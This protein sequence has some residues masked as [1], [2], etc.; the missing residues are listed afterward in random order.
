M[1]RGGRRR[2]RP[3]GAADWM[4]PPRVWVRAVPTGP[5]PCRAPLLGPAGRGRLAAQLA[6]RAE[7]PSAYASV[8]AL[9]P[10]SLL[11]TV[12]G[13]GCPLRLCLPLLELQ[14]AACEA[15]EAGLASARAAGAAGALGL[16]AAS[17]LPPPAL[18]LRPSLGRGRRLGNRLRQPRLPLKLVPGRGRKVQGRFREGTWPGSAC[19]WAGGGATIGSGARPN[20]SPV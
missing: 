11:Q 9:H 4:K 14:A 6:P 1:L 10:G 8:T 20:E 18:C 16:P 15:V 17:V 12:G 5:H 2:R 19:G 7:P 3:L 13:P